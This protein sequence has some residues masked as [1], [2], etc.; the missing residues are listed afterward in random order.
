MRLN[1]NTCEKNAV[2]RAVISDTCFM[3]Q[4]CSLLVAE[5]GATT[6]MLAAASRAR[7]AAN[8]HVAAL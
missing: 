8:I 6:S 5:L 4:P 3:M 1:G 7:R 2:H